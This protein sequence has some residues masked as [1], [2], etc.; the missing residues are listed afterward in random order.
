MRIELDAPEA[1]KALAIGERDQIA[2][3]IQNLID[4]AVKYSPDGAAVSVS[5]EP[6]VPIDP[7]STAAD[8]AALRDSGGGRLTLLS[9]ERAHEN[10]YVRARV[11][12][13]GRGI[14]REHLPRLT[15]RFYRVPGQKSGEIGGTGLGLAIVKHVVNRHR[16]ALVVESAPGIGTTFTVY[17]PLAWREEGATET[18][19]PAPAV[20]KAL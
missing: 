19:E 1:G 20:T 7:E 9:P 13:R 11:R 17:L 2:Q 12:D 14:A 6:D 18:P 4:N 10:R 8:H 15:E 16:G 3:V 5:V